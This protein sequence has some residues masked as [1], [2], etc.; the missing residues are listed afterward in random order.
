MRKVS[1]DFWFGPVTVVVVGVTRRE[2]GNSFK[3][4]FLGPADTVFFPEAA[5]HVVAD[6][7]PEM[8]Y[9]LTGGVCTL[10]QGFCV[11]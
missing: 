11:Y 7:D 9:V 5:A 2:F 1:M 3:W 8:P 4:M 6:L 10:Y